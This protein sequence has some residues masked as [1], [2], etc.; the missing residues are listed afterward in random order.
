MT[1]LLHVQAIAAAAS[2]T[3]GLTLL[4]FMMGYGLVEVP[5]QGGGFK[6]LGTG[7]VHRILGNILSS[8]EEN[9]FIIIYREISFYHI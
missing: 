6:D 8:A 1:S 3:W 4:V 2:N 7:T 5:T 9:Y